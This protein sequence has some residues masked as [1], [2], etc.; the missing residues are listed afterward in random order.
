MDSDALGFSSWV[1]KANSRISV[2]P[3]SSPPFLF[4]VITLDKLLHSWFCLLA[5]LEEWSGLNLFQFYNVPT[6][7]SVV[8]LAL[9][10]NQGLGYCVNIFIVALVFTFLNIRFLLSGCP[11]APVPASITS[12]KSLDREVLVTAIFLHLLLLG[13]ES[14]FQ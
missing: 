13:L 1:L 4:V 7:N 12:T 2:L 3:S 8:G 9:Q 11:D 14:C 10:P 6:L 5:S